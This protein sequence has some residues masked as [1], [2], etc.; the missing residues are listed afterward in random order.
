MSNNRLLKSVSLI[1]VLAVLFSSAVT[2]VYAVNR[3]DSAD[4]EYTVKQ[5]IYDYYDYTYEESM[6]LFK[7]ITLKNTEQPNELW[8]LSNELDKYGLFENEI[9]KADAAYIVQTEQRYFITFESLNDNLLYLCITQNGE[10][11]FGRYADYNKPNYCEYVVK[12]ID[13]VL[14]QLSEMCE[15]DQKTYAEADKIYFNDVTGHWAEDTINRWADKGIISGYPDGT[16]KPDNPVTRAELAKVLTLA[17]DLQPNEYVYAADEISAEAW[18]YNYLLC[19]GKY[20][21]VYALPE[22][23]YKNKPYE[24]NYNKNY[25]LPEENAIRMHVAEG[26]AE[27]KRE[28]YNL[29]VELPTIQEI[30]YELGEMFQYEDYGNLY[31]MHGT[32]PKN[33]QRMHEYTYL[34]VKLGIMQGD[35]DGYF[36]PYDGVTRA[37]LITMLDRIITE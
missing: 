5:Y 15:A 16:F 33:V 17:F 9:S 24:D 13:K 8:Y 18:Y 6:P 34:A 3:D 26:L 11:F 19:A 2:G 10:M 28:K 31:A 21:P 12:D 14:K 22:S 25:F 37:E 36:R 1:I 32:V 23:N 27:L 4:G 20:I 29:T 35:T 7:K 30:A